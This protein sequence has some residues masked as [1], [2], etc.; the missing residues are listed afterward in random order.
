MK[1]WPIVTIAVVGIGVLAS[2]GSSPKPTSNR[3]E[4]M[5]AHMIKLVEADGV[6]VTPQMAAQTRKQLEDMESMGGLSDDLYR[7]VMAATT[8]AE[9][10]ATCWEHLPA[11]PP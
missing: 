8:R 1:I 7:C 11:T 5:L 2:L 9:A 10:N 6:T 4:T 3:V